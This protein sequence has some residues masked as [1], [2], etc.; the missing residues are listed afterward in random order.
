MGKGGQRIEGWGGGRMSGDRRT[1]GLI[2]VDK[3][4]QVYGRKKRLHKED[5]YLIAMD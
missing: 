5:T 4:M 3:G 2:M 1:W